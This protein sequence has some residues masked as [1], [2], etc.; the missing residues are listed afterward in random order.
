MA[1]I[2]RN[3]NGSLYKLCFTGDGGVG[4][5]SIINRYIGQGFQTN[6]KV[7]IGCQIT[8]YNHVIEGENT[9]FQ[10]WD[11]A[12]QQRFEFVRST[13]YRG[14][15]A[16]VLVFDRTRPQSLHN[17]RRW[18][19]EILSNVGYKIPFIILGNKSDLKEKIQVNQHELMEIISELK[20]Q[21][22]LIEI[23]HFF[24]SAQ[25]GLNLKE[26]LTSIGKILRKTIPQPIFPNIF[27][28]Q[29]VVNAS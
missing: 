23:P 15:H 21:T 9:K 27:K 7:T 18:R 13:F 5:T 24:T 1:E 25:S 20:Q 8:T 29:R 26:A 19:E 14:S 17:L 4:K 2:S 3:N 6:Y 16:A 10:L 12:G 22:Q 11:L 28:R